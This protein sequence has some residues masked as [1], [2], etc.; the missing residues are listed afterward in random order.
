MGVLSRLKDLSQEQGQ[1]SYQG[2]QFE[3]AQDVSEAEQ[4]MQSVPIP[5]QSL[6][7]P[8]DSKLPYESP[9]KF[10]ELQEFIDET[11]LRL[12]DP[13]KLEQLYSVW[14]QVFHWNI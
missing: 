8:V 10:T 11:F 2:P 4:M 1:E 12:S 9:P 14:N 13:E 7:Q 3:G 6:T 5:G